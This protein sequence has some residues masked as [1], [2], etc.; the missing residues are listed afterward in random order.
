MFIFGRSPKQI[1]ANPEGL[2]LLTLDKMP[3]SAY[4]LCKCILT[5]VIRSLPMKVSFP[6]L[7]FRNGTFFWK[8][9]MFGQKERGFQ[10]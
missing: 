10:A 4:V 2:T 6:W 7:T 5:L 3:L 8:V 9:V 1:H